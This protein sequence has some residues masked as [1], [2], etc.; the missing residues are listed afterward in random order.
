MI[1]KS[2]LEEFFAAVDGDFPVRLSE[3][4]NIGEWCEKLL[5]NGTVCAEAIDGELAAVVAGYANNH[6][7]KN[8]YI[9]VAAVKRN[10]RRRGLGA[11]A[12]SKFIKK[13]GDAGMET[14]YLYVHKSNGAAIRMYKGI[15][16]KEVESD[17]TDS[18]RLSVRCGD[19]L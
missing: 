10:F 17:R 19:I 3:R 7:E 11:A 5:S 2:E 16:F 15:G 12:V 14:V 8:G 4:V 1:S 18:L 13:A 6:E 9:A